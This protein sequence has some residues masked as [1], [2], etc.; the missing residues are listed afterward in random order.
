MITL[1]FTLDS[2]QSYSDAVVNELQLFLKH[3][4]IIRQHEQIVN[5]ITQA[6]V[7]HAFN[8]LILV[9]N[10]INVM[11]TLGQIVHFLVLFNKMTNK[12]GALLTTII[13][14]SLI[15]SLIMFSSLVYFCNYFF[16]AFI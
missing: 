1:N 6:F 11:F 16:N 9:P 8:L 10:L 4:H 7:T 3:Q 2:T 12:Y 15:V 5:H 13:F 14:T